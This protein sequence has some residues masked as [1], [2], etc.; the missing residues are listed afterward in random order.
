MGEHGLEGDAFEAFDRSFLFAVLIPNFDLFVAADGDE[1]AVVVE[2][3]GERAAAVGGPAL[4][5]FAVDH[6]PQ[7]HGTVLA[8]GGKH[9]GV[10]SPTQPSDVVFVAV[11]RIKKIAGERFPNVQAAVA[12]A[13]GQQH[14]VGR[15]GN[16]HHPVRM[17]LDVV[18]RFAGGQLE[19]LDT[20]AWTA[21]GD[22]C[23]VG[24]YVS[25]EH[26]VVLL[27]KRHALSAGLDIPRD[28]PAGLAAAPASGDEQLAVAA[29]GK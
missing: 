19:H 20:L 9:V 11:E 1:V 27:A 14:G 24:H 10:E 8:G 15:K 29:E 26:G 22:G 3:H 2:L 16:G 23:E 17:F 18:Q 25:G 12:I 13:G 28:H 4:D 7:S 21:E 6:C 5:L